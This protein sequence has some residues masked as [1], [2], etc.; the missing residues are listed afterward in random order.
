MKKI[1]LS[2]VTTRIEVETSIL[3]ASGPG[4]APKGNLQSIGKTNG[5]W[6]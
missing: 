4:F 6:S 3:C 5:A 2:P 1:Y